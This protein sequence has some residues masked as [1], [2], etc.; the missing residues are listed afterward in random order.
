M[1]HRRKSGIQVS[2]PSYRLHKQSGQAV[3]TLPDART[4]KGKD[5]LLGEYGSE[6]SK[7]EYQRVIREW[8]EMKRLYL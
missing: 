6:E 2:I 3:V 7:K 1:N 8:Q 4:G 5:M